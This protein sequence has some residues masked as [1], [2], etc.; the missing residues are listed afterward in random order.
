[1]RDIILIIVASVAFLIVVKRCEKPKVVTKVKTEIKYITDTI[2]KTEISKPKVVYYNKIV[3]DTIYS[4]KDSIVYR[5]KKYK[6]NE[7]TTSLQANNATAKLKITTTGQLLDVNGVIIYPKETKT[8]ETI[9]TR[10]ASGLF[11]YGAI[12]FENNIQLP[13]VGL[14]YQF[15]NTL[16]VM[17][18]VEYNPINN[19]VNTKIGVLIRVY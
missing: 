3:N 13:E 16:G 9:K 19:S 4:T 17:G 8:I 2:T 5:N 10:N 6:A 18:G 1:M 11:L 14:M 15:K 12:P 7:Y